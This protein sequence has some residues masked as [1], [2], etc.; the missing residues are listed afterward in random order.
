MD[1]CIAQY[2]K[3]NQC[4]IVFF[5]FLILGCKV[6]ATQVLH[7]GFKQG[8]SQR[9]HPDVVSTASQVEEDA[10]ERIMRLSSSLKRQGSQPGNSADKTS[11][12]AAGEWREI[13]FTF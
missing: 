1:S 10:I 3:F 6:I 5:L 2:N 9:T 11:Q 8:Q 12:S 7:A 4:C 13:T